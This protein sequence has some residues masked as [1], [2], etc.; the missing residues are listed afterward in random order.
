MQPPRGAKGNKGGLEV[1]ASMPLLTKEGPVGIL[2]LAAPGPD[3]FDDEALVFLTAVGRAL[4]LAFRRASLQEQQAKERELRAKLE[5]RTRLANDIHRS[6]SQF[7][8]AA[9]SSLQVARENETQRVVALERSSSLVTSS[10]SGLQELDVLLN[11]SKALQLLTPK[12]FEV[13]SLISRGLTNKQIAKELDIAE[14]TVK[15]HVSNVLAKLELKGR[16]Q[17]A[18]WAKEQGL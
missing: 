4:G 8:L 3:S 14:K 11:P 5:E 6:V 16:T 18:L 1:H 15:V 7:L 9:G 10:L 12:E 13:L 2:N 17:A